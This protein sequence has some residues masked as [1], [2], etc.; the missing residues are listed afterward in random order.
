VNHVVLPCTSTM[1]FYHR[2]KLMGP[3]SHE[4]NASQTVWQTNLLSY[5]HI[6][7]VNFYCSGNLDNTHINIYI[8][9]LTRVLSSY[10]LCYFMKVIFQFS[11]LTNK[12]KNKS[13]CCGVLL[14]SQL[15]GD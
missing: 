13:G 8:S 4:L 7:S 5:N 3:N 14:S 2:P 15:L 9:L 12:V 11:N 6:I 1:M 10:F